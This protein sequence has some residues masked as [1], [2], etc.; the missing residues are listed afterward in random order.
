MTVSV[1]KEGRRSQFRYLFVF[2]FSFH[3]FFFLSKL[4]LALSLLPSNLNRI[5]DFCLQS[6]SCQSS[7]PLLPFIARSPA[8]SSP[9][10]SRFSLSWSYFEFLFFSPMCVCAQ[11]VYVCIV[12]CV[13]QNFDRLLVSGRMV[14]SQPRHFLSCYRFFPS[15]AFLLPFPSLLFPFFGFWSKILFKVV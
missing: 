6:S 14:V 10:I 7:L 12:F 13:R 11:L 1:C 2:T 3:R 9:F 15:A 8:H 5:F 4:A